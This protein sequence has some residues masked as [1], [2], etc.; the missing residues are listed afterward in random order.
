MPIHRQP[1]GDGGPFSCHEEVPMSK[2]VK[3]T[4][5]ENDAFRS[6]KWDELTAGRD[7]SVEGRTVF[8]PPFNY[9]KSV[10]GSPPVSNRGWSH[11]LFFNNL[12]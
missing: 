2:L 6:A 12:F 1:I 9:S 11:L 8:V 4:N 5:I 3:P 10:D 7:F